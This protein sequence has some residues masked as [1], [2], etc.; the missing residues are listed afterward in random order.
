ML[1]NPLRDKP[2][3]I[4][5]AGGMTAGPIVPLLAVRD[6][7]VEN[8]KSAQRDPYFIIL[9]V[10]GS[11][12]QHLAQREKIP[13]H[14][15]TSG[16]LRRYFSWRNLATP[17]L[18]LAG[19]C[20]ALYVLKRQRIT[21]VIG[22]GGFV[23]LPVVWAAWLLRLRTHIHQQDVVVTLSN[24]LSAPAAKTISV[25]FSSSL[26]D[27]PR[28]MGM[29]AH[30]TEAKVVWTG[31]PFRA[32][33]A[34]ASRLEAQQF[35]HLDKSWPTLYIMGGGSGAAGINQLVFRALPELCR[36][37]QIIHSMG[38]G[39]GRPMKHE[40]YHAFEFVNRWDLALAAADIVISRAGM[41]AITELS[42][43]GKVGIIIPMPNSHQEMNAELLYSKKAA[44]VMDQHETSPA[45]LVKTVRRL[46]FD[47]PT[48]QML[49]QNIKQIMPHD[50]AKQIAKLL[51]S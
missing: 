39:R 6:Y 10:K 28:S 16:R 32:H 46:L 49:Q 9:D 33:L 20:Q 26:R 13:F 47:L 35:F 19:F 21:H 23:Q 18:L 27:F 44:I 3:R 51:I 17:V 38:K 45:H 11:V 36:T 41:A 42:N 1:N 30:E 48:Q 2:L 15:V 50:S 14:H 34:K 29:F 12:G 5:L 43:L 40:R 8:Y 22:G 24:S 37:V 4:A 25:T 31:N 7:I